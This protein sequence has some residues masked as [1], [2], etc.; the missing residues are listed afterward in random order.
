MPHATSDPDGAV[1]GQVTALGFHYRGRPDS[2]FDDVAFALHSEHVSALVGANGSGKTTLLRLLAGELEPTAG[3]VT[4]QAT[5]FL[6]QEDELKQ[7][8]TLLEALLACEPELAELHHE[9]VGAEVAGLPDPLGYADAVAAFDA[10][11]GFGH[12]Q[13]LVALVDRV[14]VGEAALARSAAALSGGQRRLLRIGAALARGSSLVLLDEPDNHL[15]DTALERLVDL[16]RGSHAA[17]LMVTH[18]RWLMDTLADEVLELERGRLRRYRG[19]YSAYREERRSDRR[20][21]DREQQRLDA[22]IQHLARAERSYRIWGERKEAEKSGTLDKGF[23]GARAARLMKRGLAARQRIAER[24]VELEAK[25]PW[26]DK[27]YRVS[28]PDVQIPGGTCLSVVGV[29]LAASDGRAIS[30]G[31]VGRLVGDSGSV[32]E[33][34]PT[35]LV[36]RGVGLALAWGDRVAVTGANGSGKTTLLK[37]LAR[38]TAPLGGR[39]VWDSRVKIGY[40][41]QESRTGSTATVLEMFDGDDVDEA[42]RLLGALGVGGGLVSGPLR[43]LSSGQRRKVALAAIM[44]EAPTVLVLDEPTTHLDLASIEMLEDALARYR[45]TIIL[46]SHDRY[47]RERLATR[48]WHVHDGTV[49]DLGSYAPEPL[50]SS[51]RG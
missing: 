45:G 18:N 48:R 8:G 24:R 22:A 30:G 2:L 12:L 20:W 39:L 4:A 23:V 9:V 47:L 50:S 46:V 11:G 42:R 27:R 13:K 16:V 3:T 32:G 15:D 41:P 43:A 31:R 40:L 17:V 28:F 51:H 33:G 1:V 25:R 19:G 10:A 29:D 44:V 34:G 35:A 36:L 37:A 26:V 6:T 14:G 7:A 21:R 5:T 49:E 38:R